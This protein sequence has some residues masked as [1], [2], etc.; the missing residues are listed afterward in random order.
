[1]WMFWSSQR[2]P[3]ARSA[4]CTPASAARWFCARLAALHGWMTFGQRR[5]LKPR[6][7]AGRGSRHELCTFMRRRDIAFAP[8]WTLLV[9]VQPLWIR[10]FVTQARGWAPGLDSRGS[11]CPARSPRTGCRSL[12]AC[13]ATR[14]LG[15]QHQPGVGGVAHQLATADAFCTHALTRKSIGEGIRWCRSNRAARDSGDRRSRHRRRLRR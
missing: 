3:S 6:P 15:P 13:S 11:R 9:E 12:R 4:L 8:T 10:R 7:L 14:D 2:L 5:Q 1:M